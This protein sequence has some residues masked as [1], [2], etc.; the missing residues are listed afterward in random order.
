MSNDAKEALLVVLIGAIIM[1]MAFY[2]KGDAILTALIYWFQKLMHMYQEI[3]LK[4]KE[5]F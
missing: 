3:G 2:F 1:F 4:L 5:L